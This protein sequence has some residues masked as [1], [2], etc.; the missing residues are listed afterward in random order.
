[1]LTMVLCQ[2][3]VLCFILTIAHWIPYILQLAQ[4][5]ALQ[6]KFLLT[7]SAQAVVEHMSL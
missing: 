2:C 5:I 1:M 4:E 3:L 7:L 6:F